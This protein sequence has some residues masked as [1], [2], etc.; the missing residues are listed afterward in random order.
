MFTGALSFSSSF[1]SIHGRAARQSVVLD[2]HQDS[3]P[4]TRKVD[5]L[6]GKQA[7]NA[8]GGRASQSAY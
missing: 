7:G 5:R 2:C 6:K 1:R 3:I 4:H 8:A